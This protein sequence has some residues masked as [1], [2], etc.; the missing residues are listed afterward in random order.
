MVSH[1]VA[2]K[3]HQS[4]VALVVALM[5]L[6]IISVIGIAA[7][8]TSLFSVKVATSAQ[9]S[10][11]AFQSAESALA[12]IFNEATTV[13]AST[14]GHVIRVAVDNMATGTPSVVSRC[15]T[16][17]NT[18]TQHACGTTEF[19]DSRSLTK[20]ESRTVIK[21]SGRAVKG[22]GIGNTGGTTVRYYDFVSAAHGAVP[23]LNINRYNVQEYTIQQ[24]ASPPEI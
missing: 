1:G 13:P 9:A 11:M 7:M 20:S 22:S 4:G 6:V 19:A 5:I 8:R 16:P 3:R 17:G 24:L 2:Y 21:P 18:Y 15:V 14:P 10:G 12:A 23:V